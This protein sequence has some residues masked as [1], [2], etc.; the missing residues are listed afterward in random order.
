MKKLIWLL[1][2]SGILGVALAGAPPTITLLSP[3]NGVTWRIGT[4][5][6]IAAGS[7]P[8]THPSS[9]LRFQPFPP[10]RIRSGVYQSVFTAF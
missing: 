10:T 4:V 5:D 9:H 8:V 2:L 1:I 6:P 7:N 3:Q